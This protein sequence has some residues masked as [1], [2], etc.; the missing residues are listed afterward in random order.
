MSATI[1]TLPTFTQARHAE[2]ERNAILEADNAWL[3]QRLVEAT[4]AN[5]ELARHV[6]AAEE[7]AEKAERWVRAR[8]VAHAWPSVLSAV[9]TALVAV[10]GLKFGGW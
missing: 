2:S 4:V 1:H 3:E 10:I 8:L 6:I 9:T 7:R 5:D